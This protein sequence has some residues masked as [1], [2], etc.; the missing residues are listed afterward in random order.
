MS[1]FCVT[2][3]GSFCFHVE[4]LALTFFGLQFG[5][6]SGKLY[7]GIIVINSNTNVKE[8]NCKNEPV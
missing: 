7:F 4:I 3:A 1:C 5:P 8:Q 2:G 6:N